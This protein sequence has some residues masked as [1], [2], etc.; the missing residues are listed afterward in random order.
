MNPEAEEL[1]NEYRKIL[2][3]ALRQKRQ[4]INIDEFFESDGEFRDELMEIEREKKEREEKLRYNCSNCKY[5]LYFS[6]TEDEDEFFYRDCL[7]FEGN[8]IFNEKIICKK[9]RS[10]IEPISCKHYEPKVN[11]FK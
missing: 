1:I 9:R 5:E 4:F 6:F 3:E 8:E 7:F 2:K 10:E 11:N